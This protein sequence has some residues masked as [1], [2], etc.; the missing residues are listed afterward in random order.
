MLIAVATELQET[1]GAYDE[2]A[3]LIK[4]GNKRSTLKE[5]EDTGTQPKQHGQRSMKDEK[6]KMHDGRQ[7]IQ[8]DEKFNGYGSKILKMMGELETMWD[9]HLDQITIARIE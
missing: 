7:E 6:R 4:N 8:M 2:L 1:I 9:S 3:P 5:S